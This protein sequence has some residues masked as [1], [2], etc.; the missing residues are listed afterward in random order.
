[1]DA[2]GQRFWLLS[3]QVHWNLIGNPSGAEY[4]SARRSLRLSSQR[5]ELIFNDDAQL[6]E[7]RLELTPQTLDNYGNRAYWDDA[8]HS[9]I[10]T[11]ALESEVIIFTAPDAS[12]EVTDIVMGN[13]G[14]LYIAIDGKIVM[15]D[16]RER[17]KEQNVEVPG[18]SDFQA[19][20]MTADPNEGVWVLDRDNQRLARVRGMPLHKL[21]HRTFSADVTRPCSE[22]PNPPRMIEVDK[23][24][25][26]A[27]E[28]P[29]AIACSPQGKLAVLSWVED[30][31]ASV[32]LLSEQLQLTSPVA[33]LGSAR[34]YSM[35]WVSESRMAFLLAGVTEEA[36]VYRM[37]SGQD[38]M[39]PVGD[40]YPL[41]K[42]FS[43]APFIHSL[44]LPPHYPTADG[45]RALHRLSFPF[46]A[47]EGEASNDQVIAPLDSKSAQMTWHRLFIEAVIPKGC[48]IKV[49]LATT[50]DGLPLAA[51]DA[52]QWYEHRFGKMFEQGGRADIPIG[53]WE[54]TASEIP[55]ETGLLPCEIERD[56]S[57]LFS[58]LIQRSTRRVRS[59]TGRYLHVYVK[60]IG[61]GHATP[62][63]FAIRAYGSRFSYINQYLPQLYRESTFL[64]E[65]DDEGNATAP[66]F[67][68]RYIGNVE[69]V[70][71]N[72][73]DRI[74]SSY[75][76][77]CPQ[78]VPRDSLAWLGSWIGYDLDN[79]LPEYTQR[80]FL[81][82]APELY[83][84][85]GT[86]RGLKAA[87]EIATDGGVSGGEIVVLE[88]F[89]LRRTFA[90]IIGADLDDRDDPLT[91]GGA[92]SGNSYVGDTLFI[93]D[94][95]KKE[96]LALFSSDLPV[97]TSEQK[98]IDELFDKLAY[99]VTILVHQ[100][101]EP[102]DL[103]LI[104]RIAEH[105]M[106]AHVEF[107]VLTAS[108][109]FLVGMA[110][111]VGVDTYLAK[112][113]PTKQARIGKGHL[114]FRDFVY[115]PAALD[116]RLEGIGSGTP[117]SFDKPPVAIAPDVSANFGSSI[118][119]DASES[120]A[121]GGREIV[122]YDWEYKSEE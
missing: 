78:T 118:L 8:T 5:R 26:P 109:P 65:A 79:S 75:L 88:D 111:L 30:T 50:R 80:Q 53:V 57:G 112:R 59:L 58:V 71:T 29:V 47:K 84:W 95:N 97:D 96:F 34:P 45:S 103:G 85:H 113:I 10:A 28:R 73:E 35:H 74:A 17:W 44:Q 101:V 37:D 23:V 51:I 115:G 116:P 20:R 16:R 98:A 33:L 39:W 3:D 6:A 66:D 42:N 69:G 119:L 60:L 11:G 18:L 41:K 67:L 36:P 9:I 76:L 86:L 117:I 55:H 63:I 91:A 27:G 24:S 49:W 77:T 19:W 32:R 94:E 102:Q 14:V 25:W 90:T 114:G 56:K 64:P 15:H 62:E 99:R 87:L 43:K 22:N 110:S 61:N 83:R 105:E 81:Q 82:A 100:E 4:D 70:L 2:N 1:V 121:F 7:E 104:Q 13:D 72:I 93:G 122:S 12:S 120:R 54:S 108:N 92:V 89:R 21:S 46:F 68:E 31:N 107:R 40:L 106:P 48:G 52:S 38:G